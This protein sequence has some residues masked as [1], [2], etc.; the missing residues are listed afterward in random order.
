MLAGNVG[1]GRMLGFRTLTA[2]GPGPR[3]PALGRTSGASPSVTAGHRRRP[4]GSL[5]RL[6]AS[7]L[8]VAACG[9][10][11]DPL[12]TTRPSPTPP[13]MTAVPSSGPFA[14]SAY[15]VAGDA[16]CSQP[17]SPDTR[18]GAYTGN[19]KRISS[20]NARTVVFTLCG[21][22]VAFLSKIASPAFS[23]NDA[24]WLASHID[25]T[26]TGPQAIVSEVNGTGPYRLESW[27]PG[28]EVSLARGPAYWGPAAKNE[29]LIVRWNADSSQRVKELQDGT[30]DG[31][32]GIV[33]AGVATMADNVA[34][35]VL[36]R[37]GLNVFY[38]GLDNAFPPFDNEKVRQAIA[39]GV[40]RRHIVDVFFPPGSTVASHYAPCTIPHGCVGAGWY[41]YDPT[42][43]KEM[44]ATAGFPSGFDTTIHYADAAQPFLPA[45]AGV[46]GELRDELL[47]NL[48]IHATLV[49]EPAATYGSDA[50]S[51]KLDGIHLLGQRPSYPDVTT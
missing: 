21:P 6:L 1:R 33:P 50:D 2:P 16:P 18:H 8:L 42:L 26:S 39:I 15:P 4:P 7:V 5:A 40:D 30:V 3:A 45:P 28:T 24:G 36:P 29:R 48:G 20:T 43:A 32:D 10:T 14:R 34:L 37:P 12:P 19:I 38:L 23:I 9:S 41:D 11:I 35:T 44:L 51:G 25:P 13:K 22:D 27:K 31:I 49:V 46:A 17:A 47:A